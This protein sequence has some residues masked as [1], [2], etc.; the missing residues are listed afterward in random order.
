MPSR[1]A[2]EFFLAR[3]RVRLLVSAARHPPTGSIAEA[4][5]ESC[6]HAALAGFVASWEAY[7]E[8]LVREVQQQIADPSHA[9]LSAIL[10]LL[11]PISEREVKR[12]NTPNAENARNLLIDHTGYDPINDWH[13]PKE[14]LT[15][16]QTRTRLDEILR[17][18]HSFAHGFPIPTDIA[19]ARNRN[20]NG[21]L[22]ISALRN[23]D[24]FLSHMVKITD[25]GMSAHLASAFGV[26]SGW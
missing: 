5:K 6:L 15:G 21:H 20:S 13:W 26:T 25:A 10:A 23:V 9:R 14:T 24:R 2:G 19:W 18:R 22:T 4:H 3:T 17:V 1:S 11:K 8:R 7:L 16:P 12:F